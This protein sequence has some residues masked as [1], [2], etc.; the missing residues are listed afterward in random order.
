[1]TPT[2]YKGILDMAIGKEQGAA[3]FYRQVANKVK[4]AGLKQIFGELADEEQKHEALLLGFRQDETLV[5]QFDEVKDYGVA[6]LL[7]KPD[8][9]P[10]MKPAD[11]LALAVKNEEAAMNAYLQLAAASTDAKAKKAL[12]GARQDGERP[13]GPPRDHVRQHRV[14]RGLVIGGPVRE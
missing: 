8:P 7:D 6:Q 11:A 4:D 14:P 12:R 5:I 1:M 10:E 2:D 3:D 9:T 13:Q